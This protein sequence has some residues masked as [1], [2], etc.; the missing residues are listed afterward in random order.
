MARRMDHG[1]VSLGHA[2]CPTHR[3]ANYAL[4]TQS[5]ALGKE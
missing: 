1:S 4:R 5:A 2:L 3:E